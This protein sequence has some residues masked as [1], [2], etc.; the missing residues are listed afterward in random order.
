[1]CAAY[2]GP[3]YSCG[4]HL[5]RPVTGLQ[6]GQ[7][8]ERNCLVSGRRV[9]EPCE[10]TRLDPTPL[11]NEKL[12][13]ASESAVRVWRGPRSTWRVRSPGVSIFDQIIDNGFDD[14]SQLYHA[15]SLSN[16]NGFPIARTGYGF[17]GTQIIVVADYV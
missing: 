4:L 14:E 2:L 17:I 13:A 3:H 8:S 15:L 11:E 7:C 6:R 12:V 5:T 10:S 9:C 16:A 1:M